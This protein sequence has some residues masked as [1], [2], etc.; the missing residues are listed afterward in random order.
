MRMR[1]ERAGCVERSTSIL[2]A[3]RLMRRCGIPYVVVVEHG[4][5]APVPLGLVSAEDIVLRVIALGLDA[6]VV[7]AG[8]VLA[9][10]AAP[11]LDA[12]L[13]RLTS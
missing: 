6:R 4:D 8:D 9:T 2:T 10:K 5:D 12:L 13:R 1:T 3:A 7:T 11:T